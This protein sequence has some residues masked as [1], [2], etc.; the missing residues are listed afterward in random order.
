MTIEEKLKN[1]VIKYLQI[2]NKNIEDTVIR[3]NCYK[4]DHVSNEQVFTL[5]V[6]SKI[7][8]DVKKPMKSE[9]YALFE[10]LITD[11]RMERD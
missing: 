7:T 5:V 10:R 1:C 11:N 3:W 6:K 9:E 4:I 2:P 8:G